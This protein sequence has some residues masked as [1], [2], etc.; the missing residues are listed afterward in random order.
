M[1]T[2]WPGSRRGSCVA[3]FPSLSRGTAPSAG[4]T[5]ATTQAYRSTVD[6]AGARGGSEIYANLG[7]LL[8]SLDGIVSLDAETRAILEPIRTLGITLQPGERTLEFSAA[9]TVE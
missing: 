6:L 3:A 7:S 5:L 2:G 1:R 9:V 8:P 4:S